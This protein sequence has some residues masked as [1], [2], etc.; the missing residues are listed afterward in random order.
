VAANQSQTSS[1]ATLPLKRKVEIVDLVTPPSSPKR[2]KN[3]EPLEEE[4]LP[5]EVS[6]V[7]P[8]RT[9]RSFPPATSNS[10]WHWKKFEYVLVSRVLPISPESVTKCEKGDTDVVDHAKGLMKVAV[11]IFKVFYFAKLSSSKPDFR[12]FAATWLTASRLNRFLSPEEQACMW[13]TVDD[14]KNNIVSQFWLKYVPNVVDA[15]KRSATCNDFDK[16]AQAHL[17]I[18]LTENPASSTW[19]Q[20]TLF[21]PNSKASGSWSFNSALVLMKSEFAVL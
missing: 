11:G 12:N 19:G 16:F 13:K 8:S 17:A 5:L 2:I 15:L 6:N 18:V 7:P 1:S 10:Y 4:I 3:E 14:R 20:Y 21:D 9:L